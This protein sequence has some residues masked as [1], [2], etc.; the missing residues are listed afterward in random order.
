MTG[1]IIG[2]GL[3]LVICFG[4]PI[5]G[6]LFLQAGKRRCI[7]PFVLGALAFIL[8]QIVLRMPLLDLLPRYY[9][10]N[11]MVIQYPSLYYIFL[12]ITAGLFEETARA[13]FLYCL[14]R[15]NRRFCDGL[16]FGLGHGGVEAMLFTG[17]A[18]LSILFRLPAYEGMTFGMVFI[19]GLERLFAISM[20][21]GFTVMVLTGIREKK[22]IRYLLAAIALHGAADASI[23]FWQAAGITGYYLEA[24]LGVYALISLGYVYR[25]GRI[26]RRSAEADRQELK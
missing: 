5:G 17:A 2:L 4:I 3:C 15:K 10:Y 26:E 16:A 6:L 14:L 24:V 13:V 19:G 1:M 25:M 20:H 23:G 8:S 21:L 9:W 18:V 12:G 22:T 11:A 7:L